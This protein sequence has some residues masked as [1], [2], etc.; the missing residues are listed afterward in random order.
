MPEEDREVR[1][2]LQVPRSE[3]AEG[4]RGA[5]AEEA[6]GASE[7]DRV[8]K[9]TR[10]PSQYGVTM[11]S[12]FAGVGGFELGAKA[13]GMAVTAWSEYDPQATQ[14]KTQ[15][16]QRVL[17][18]RFPEAEAFADIA[19]VTYAGLGR[20]RVLT[21]GSPCQGFSVAGLRKGMLD[22]R[23]GLFAEFVRLVREGMNDGLEFAL[24]ENV[25]GALNS[26][27]GSD[28]AN[29]LAA[30]V[31]S[32]EP[33]FLPKSGARTARWAGVAMGPLGFFAWRTLDARYFGVAQRRPRVFGLWSKSM[34]CVTALFGDDAAEMI[35][36]SG[37]HPDVEYGDV[38]AVWLLDQDDLPFNTSMKPDDPCEVK[39]SSVLEREVDEKYYISEKACLGILTRATRRDRKLP[40]IFHY[41]LWDQCGRPEEFLPDPLMVEDLAAEAIPFAA[42]FIASPE[43]RTTLAPGQPSPTITNPSKHGISVVVPVR[44]SRRAH[45]N[46][47]WETWE[48]AEFSNTVNEFDFG[49]DVRATDVV[50]GFNLDP[51]NHQGA[52]LKARRTDTAPGL[53]PNWL[54]KTT[55]RGLRVVEVPT[56]R[57]RRLTPRECERL[58]G[59]PDNHTLVA[60]AADS[61]RYR[62]MGNAV[63]VPCAAWVLMRLRAVIDG[64]EVPGLAEVLKELPWVRVSS[65]GSE[66]RRVVRKK[67]RPNSVPRHGNSAASSVSS[68][69]PRATS[70][71]TKRRRVVRRVSS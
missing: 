43:D 70:S 57:V 58:Q 59:F 51:E 47:D 46:E 7:D 11:A 41:A 35:A 6:R 5:G 29:V 2:R 34:D 9:V 1:L 32:E 23:S 64:R 31:G 40:P 49:K 66:T 63:A 42:A 25:P 33:L 3:E 21:A 28:F 39:L 14:E 4:P 65:G 20:P 45:H 44:K 61:H 67:V 36:T 18:E 52:D 12:G 30:M 15:P 13:A 27:K 26:A 55:D 68:R 71:S 19:S 24:W 22:H 16:N 69:S 62:Q 48:M 53:A 8:R 56:Y 10:K 54:A 17:L 37:W 60:G 38:T 50:V